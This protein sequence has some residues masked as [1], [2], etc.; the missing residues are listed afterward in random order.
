MCNKLILVLTG[1]LLFL[2]SCASVQNNSLNPSDY[3]YKAVQ[4]FGKQPHP[5]VES[6]PDSLR[7]DILALTNYI[8]NGAES[9]YEKIR[10]I[11]DWIALNIRYDMNSYLD[12]NRTGIRRAT[13]YPRTVLIRGQAVCAGYSN[14][15][16]FMCNVAGAKAKTIR[17][18]AGG[19][20]GIEPHAW[21][22]VLVEGKEYYIDVTADAGYENNMRFIPHY[23]KKYFMMT[24]NAIS[25]DHYR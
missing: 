6:A 16:K 24:H 22:I 19:P 11:H 18:S 17:G 2:T 25:R 5:R 1:T 14:L 4:D 13:V 8:T 7:A 23:N 3:Y 9:D 20:N 15:F 12:R 21:N 10:R